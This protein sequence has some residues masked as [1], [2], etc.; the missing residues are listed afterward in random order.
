[1]KIV[2]KFALT[3]DRRAAGYRGGVHHTFVFTPQYDPSLPE[4]RRFATATPCGELR[5][6][7][8]NPPVA[9]F[10]AQQLGQQFLIEM[11]PVDESPS[12][13]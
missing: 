11:R 2:A 6:S 10:L 4:D 9:E 1:M 12:E 5:M 3:E 13:T 7:V 8:D